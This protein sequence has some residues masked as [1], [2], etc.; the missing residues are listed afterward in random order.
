MYQK[1]EKPILDPLE[2][3]RVIRRRKQAGPTPPVKPSPRR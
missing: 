2:I 3:I 1:A